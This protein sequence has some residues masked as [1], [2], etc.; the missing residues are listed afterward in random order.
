MSA[1]FP[2]TTGGIFMIQWMIPRETHKLNVFIVVVVVGGR[3][4]LL[5]YGT[6]RLN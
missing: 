5:A 1:Y 4:E 6:Q 2:N 3:E